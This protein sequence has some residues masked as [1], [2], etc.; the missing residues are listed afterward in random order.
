L[1]LEKILFFISALQKIIN[2]PKDIFREIK[3]ILIKILNCSTRGFFVELEFE[4]LIQNFRGENSSTRRLHLTQWF[5][6]ISYFLR[7][8]TVEKLRDEF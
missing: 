1:N 5:Q 8:V 7:V 2:V 4:E 6:S 3:L